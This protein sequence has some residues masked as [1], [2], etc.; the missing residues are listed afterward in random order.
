MN[1]RLLCYILVLLT[2]IMFT[3]CGKS[4]DM[5]DDSNEPSNL[6]ITVTIP[7]QKVEVEPKLKILC[8]EYSEN[9]ISIRIVNNNDFPILFSDHFIIEQYDG[10]NWNEMEYLN[11]FGD[12]T[13]MGYVLQP[14]SS[15]TKNYDVSNVYG[16]LVKGKYRFTTDINLSTESGYS[17]VTLST[18]FQVK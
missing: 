8:E 15:V 10:E 6:D 1:F 17:P 7:I 9:V 13:D 2:I 5:R 18:E 4:D 12:F 3:S 14:V 16:V 11:S